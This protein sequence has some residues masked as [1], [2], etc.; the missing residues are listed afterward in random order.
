[1]MLPCKIPVNHG[2]SGLIML[3]YSELGDLLRLA[4]SAAHAADC[5]GYL[6]GQLC[7]SESPERDLCEEYLDLETDDDNLVEECREEIAILLTETRRFLV[8]PELDFQLL[9]PDDDAPLADRVI[10]LGEWC[11][12][13]LNG[14][15]LGQHSATVL[16]NE[17]GKE[18]IENFTNICRI[19][20]GEIADEGDEQ[21]LFE[22]VEYVRIGTIYIYDLLQ[23]PE[24]MTNRPEIYH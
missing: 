17:E 14:F 2:E 3:N 12:G 23:P 13:F 8:S 7:V 5:H 18:L 6:C 10:A 21:A 16:E 9:L 1:M 20:S 11:Y 22:L 15:A 4:G 19:E 24:P